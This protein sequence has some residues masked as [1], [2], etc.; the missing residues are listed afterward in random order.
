MKII[1]LMEARRNAGHPSQEKTRM[2]KVGAHSPNYYLEKYKDDPS[3][4]VSFSP[5][6]KLGINPLSSWSTPQ[7]I[8]FYPLSSMYSSNNSFSETVPYAG[9]RPYMFIVRS[10]VKLTNI[11]DYKNSNLKQDKENIINVF[12]KDVYDRIMNIIDQFGIGNNFTKP[13]KELWLIGNIYSKYLNDDPNTSMTLKFTNFFKKL[14]YY[15]FDDRDGSGTISVGEPK[16]SVFFST[17]DFEILE[18]ITFHKKI[19]KVNDINKTNKIPDFSKMSENE[20]E[21][22]FIKHPKLAVDYAEKHEAFAVMVQ[23]D[24][25]KHKDVFFALASK[26]PKIVPS[27]IDHEEYI[28]TFVLIAAAK[29]DKEVLK[30]L[31]SN[32]FIDHDFVRWAIKNHPDYIKY[33]SDENMITSIYKKANNHEN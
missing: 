15:G 5:I 9:D 4:Y 17:K 8:Y 32:P 2:S 16:Q 12:G 33:L 20:R 21:E 14:G 24:P 23:A 28:P 22:F 13:I 11:K 25:Y 6:P 26:F 27:V 29:K 30:E 7:G 10:K 31:L 1:D 19:N 18:M 3:I